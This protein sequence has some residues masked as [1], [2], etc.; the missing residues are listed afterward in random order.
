[1]N[2]RVANEYVDD[3]YGWI[4]CILALEAVSTGNFG[5]G[6]ILVNQASEIVA[7]GHNE[8]FKPYFRSDGHAEM[9]VMNEFEKKHKDTINLEGYVI[10]TSLESCPMCLA[11]IITSG[12]K[13]LI[14]VASDNEGGMV[15]KVSD[16]PPIWIDLA[17]RQLFR[18]AKCS[19]YIS[20]AAKNIFL[21]SAEKLDQQLRER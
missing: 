21:M 11:R 10:Y 3:K 19:E 13:K 12:I 14:Y 20:E 15:H 5:V 6:S 1:M 16:M 2:Y 7:Y 17:K 9:V 18:K 8:V 4:T